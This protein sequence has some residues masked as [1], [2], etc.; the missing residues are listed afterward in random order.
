MVANKLNQKIL[1]GLVSLIGLYAFWCSFAYYNQN[2]LERVPY[3]VIETIK[4]SQ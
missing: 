3:N 1:V 2:R 4:R